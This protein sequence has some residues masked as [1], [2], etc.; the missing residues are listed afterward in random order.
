MVEIR[1]VKEGRVEV[2]D[3]REEGRGEVGGRFTI[4]VSW[5]VP[6]FLSTFR[7]TN[8]RSPKF[9]LSSYGVTPIFDAVDSRILTTA[10][11][12]GWWA[13]EDDAGVILWEEGSKRPMVSLPLRLRRT[14]SFEDVR[15]PVRGP[16]WTG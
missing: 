8:L 13:G 15:Q 6:L 3:K 2:R 14:A 9:V 16:T 4:K 7:K 10:F 5:T 12:E 11:I 1:G